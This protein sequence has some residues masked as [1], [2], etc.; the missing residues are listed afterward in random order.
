MRHARTL[1]HK[2]APLFPNYLF[3]SLDM[4]RDPWRSVNGTCGVIRLIMQGETPES[5]PHGVVE[6]LQARMGE[7][8]AIDW[9]PSFKIGQSVRITDGP[10]ADFIGTLEHL[11]SAGRVRVLLDL[12]GRSVSVALIP[13]A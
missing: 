3:V 12:L 7:S 1:Q 10:Y 4:S 11:D 13:A 8:G 2:F 5:V 6:A 9:T